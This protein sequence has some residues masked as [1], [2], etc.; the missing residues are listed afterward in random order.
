MKTRTALAA[1]TLSALALPL[2]GVAPASAS[3]GGGGRRPY[4]RRLR[5][6]GGLEAQGQAGRRP[7]RARG[8]GRQQPLRTGLGLDDQAQ[9]QRLRE[10]VRA[11]PEAR[12]A[13]SAWSGGWPTSPGRTTSR[14]VPNVVPPAT[15]AVAPSPSERAGFPGPRAGEGARGEGAPQPG[16]AVRP[17]QPAAVRG[18]LVG[19]RAA[20]ADGRRATR[21]SRTPG[22]P[23]SCSPARWPSRRSPRVSSTATP[24]PSTASTGRCC[25]GCWCGDVR[26]IKIWR[27][28][29]TIVYSDETQLIGQKFALDD[30]QLDVLH[31]GTTEGSLSDLR[32][33]ENKFETEEDGLLEVYTRIDSP[34]GEPA[35]VRGLLLG[36]HRPAAGRRGAQ[37]VPADQRA[38][39]D[40]D[41]APRRT[42]DRGADPAADPRQ[43]GP[44]AADGAGHRLLGGR[45]PPDRP[46]PPRRRGPGAGRYG[47]R[48]VRA[49][50]ASPARRRRSRTV[51]TRSSEAL[52]R[53]PAAAAL[54]PGG[55]PPA[56]AQRRRA[57]RGPGGPHGPGGRRR[58]H[59]DGERW[60]ASRARRTTWSRWSGGSP[61]RR[62]ATRCATPGPTTVRVEVA[63]RGTAGQRSPSQD[64][65]V[66][67]DPGGRRSAGLLRPARVAEP[68]GGRRRSAAR[69]SRR[70]A[71]GRR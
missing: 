23:P 20:V 21:P 5:R 29:G 36:G 43:P 28:D 62:S 61:R 13:P 67:F 22:S 39:P 60:P 14:S 50:P 40:R 33:R 57:R 49:R 32:R 30:E 7:H 58:R 37:P 35:A 11:P 71:P 8:R 16:R 65:G 68:G 53:T 9:R 34:E 1:L 59:A 64:D 54:A 25:R 18:D 27:E 69:C 44:R 19:D 2:A 66:G 70:P 55:D 17:R 38:R 47:V 42:D 26:R 48:A 6:P 52:R 56:R 41:P 51:L 10:G 46:R 31:S 45:A 15:C 3:H 12:A 63:R 4:P 24:A